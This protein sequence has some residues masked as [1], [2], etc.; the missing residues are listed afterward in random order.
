MSQV[1]VGDVTLKISFLIALSVLGFVFFESNIVQSQWLVLSGLLAVGI[2]FSTRSSGTP[3]L[4]SLN[5]AYQCWNATSVYENRWGIFEKTPNLVRVFF[6]NASAAALSTLLMLTLLFGHLK[7]RH[8][9]D[10]GLIWGWLC[11]INTTYVLANIWVH[12]G[13]LIQP[14][15]LDVAGMNGCLI[16]STL[17]FVMRVIDRYPFKNGS[18]LFILAALALPAFAAVQAQA[19]NPYFVLTVVL[20]SAFLVIKFQ[21]YEGK[22]FW[23]WRFIV[24]C[25]VVALGLS[26][27][28]PHLVVNFFNWSGREQGY[29]IFMGA[30]LKNYHWI[31][32]FGLGTFQILGPEI[33]TVTHFNEGAWWLWLHSDWL[34]LIFETGVIGFAL[35]WLLYGK[36]LWNA[37][38]ARKWDLLVSLC[39]YGAWMVANYPFHNA[40]SAFLGAYLV[41]YALV[42]SDA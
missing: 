30:V 24:P 16:A 6:S 40:I 31:T 35:A 10:L 37:Y 33:Q 23:N 41:F 27:L 36:C 42:V 4:L 25:V 2:F 34:Q 13:K 32:G 28:G 12:H 15:F 38:C 17:P 1:R 9:E 39:G 26:W 8:F 7:R 21:D 29:P 5:I 22:S 14:G 18:F 19:T 20:F 3:T 11:L